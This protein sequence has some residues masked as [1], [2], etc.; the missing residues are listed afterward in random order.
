MYLPQTVAL[1]LL[2]C[3]SYIV[4]SHADW[5]V[6]SAVKCGL[7]RSMSSSSIRV[8]I[9]ARGVEPKQ[10]VRVLSVEDSE[11]KRA[12]ISCGDIYPMYPPSFLGLWQNQLL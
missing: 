6:L 12:D 5:D 4:S 7:G 10:L 9:K 8:R 2:V 3:V 1:V 11:M